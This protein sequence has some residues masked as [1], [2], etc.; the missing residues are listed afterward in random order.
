M[1]R[2]NVLKQV[3]EELKNAAKKVFSAMSESPVE[4]ATSFS[5]IREQVSYALMDS[6]DWMW[7]IDLYVDE[8]NGA[9]FA[10]SAKEGL[11]YQSKVTISG[12]VVTLGDPVQVQQYFQ[13]AQRNKMVIKRQ[14]DGT[15]R[16]FLQASSTVLNR[17]G[18]IDSSQ[19]F[20]NMN[21]RAK[22]T[23]KYPFLTFFHMGEALK[24]GM[25]DWLER[26]DNILLA[27]G[28]Y[29][30]GNVFAEHM[31]KAYEED[32]EYWGSSISFYPLEGRMEEI[33]RDVRVPMYTDGEYV[34]ISVLP[35]L[36]ACSLFTALH[37]EGKVNNMKKEVEEAVRRVMGNDTELADQ[38]IK[39]V[40]GVNEEIK[41]RG[42]I[43]REKQEEVVIPSPDPETPAETPVQTSPEESVIELDETTVSEIV[44]R[45]SKDP[46]VRK[47]FQ[48]YEQSLLDVKTVL[49]QNVKEFADFRAAYQAVSGKT[50]S[51]LHTLEKGSEERQKEWTSDLPRSNNP[52]HIVRAKKVAES[53]GTPVT[54]QDIAENTLSR[55]K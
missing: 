1:E 52:V 16:W 19:L 4:Q 37:S 20:D 34:E 55:I 40:D 48:G 30:K 2:S 54:S 47:I 6:G 11:I 46:E 13:P 3:Y 18:S 39:A 26:A 35:E 41:N 49:E 38:I 15:V 43:S 24:M 29:D 36:A 23:G 14:A 8:S 44:T 25:T 32:P 50:D 7:L 51:R 21:K 22:E 53:G 28:T 12:D 9:M 33:S 17:N 10:I 45:V 31:I 27:S 5:G 42:L